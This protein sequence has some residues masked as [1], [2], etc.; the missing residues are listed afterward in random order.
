MKFL[1]NPANHLFQLAHS[2]KRLPHL[3]IAVL[4][5]IV[6]VFASAFTGGILAIFIIA[7][8]SMAT[9]EVSTEMLAQGLRS[10]NQQVL[11][12]IFL[13]TTALEQ[14]IYLVLSFG[15][16][17]LLLWVWLALFEKRPLRTIGLER[18]RAA[19]KYLRGLLV[20]LLMFVASIGISAVL[21]YIAVEEGSA[22]PRGWAALGGVLLL[23]LGWMVQGSA[24]E[25]LTRGWLLPVIGARYRPVL[26][27]IISSAI[28]T[29][30]H[31]LNPNLSP[32]AILNLFL[33]GLF[34]ALYA[35]YE[36]GLWGV[37]S[38]HA[39][40][41]WAQGNVFGFEVSGGMAPGGTLFDLMEVG[42]DIVTGGPF[43]PEGGLA[44]TIVLVLS[45]VIIWLVSRRK[46]NSG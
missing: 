14:T 17:F 16:I 24:E 46:V 34:T 9:G 31:S 7:V 5:S 42:P 22:Q 38:I 13:P 23:F 44:V 26:G 29:I 18:P 37:F 2:G 40:W 25:A 11:L 15:P 19:T 4:L 41:N 1:L 35:L 27:V 30:F 43:G 8:L 6:F 32:V 20:G 33:F 45:C 12:N 36:G 21:G 39:A 28:F 3:V 10:N